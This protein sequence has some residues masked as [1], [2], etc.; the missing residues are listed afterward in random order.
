VKFFSRLTDGEFAA[1]NAGKWLARR[2]DWMFAARASRDA[3]QVELMRVQV[4]AARNCNRE[5]L[6]QVAKWRA[7]REPKRRRA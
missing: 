6:K 5:Y 2:D 4:S 7:A 1:F 3:R